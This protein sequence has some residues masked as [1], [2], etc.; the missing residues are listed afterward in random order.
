MFIY[1]ENNETYIGGEP[2]D[3]SVGLECLVC[4]FI[5]ML[6]VDPKPIERVGVLVFRTI[7]PLELKGDGRNQESF[8]ECPR[9]GHKII[10][11][12]EGG[13]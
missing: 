9:C 1:E 4:G 7:I 2:L 8:Y 6:E 5:D 12:E 11:I 13:E 10:C 3:G